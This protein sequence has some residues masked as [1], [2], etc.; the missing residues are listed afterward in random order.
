MVSFQSTMPGGVGVDEG[1]D[2]F[3]WVVAK[4]K[5][6]YD[7]IFNTLEQD[8]GKVTGE[9]QIS[10]IIRIKTWTNHQQKK[11]KELHCRQSCKGGDDE[12]TSAQQGNKSPGFPPKNVP[13]YT[14]LSRCLAKCGSL[15]TR[16]T[17]ECWTVR[18]LLSPCISSR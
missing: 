8:K 3:G 9:I 14:I 16:T 1:S 15:R 10:F 6:K 17:T 2:E 18:N 12:V 11:C 4:D 5:P 7:E 13:S